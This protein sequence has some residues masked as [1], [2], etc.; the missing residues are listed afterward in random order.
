MNMRNILVSIPFVVMAGLANA[1]EDPVRQCLEVAASNYDENLPLGI[2]GVT[3]EELNV[4]IAIELCREVAESINAD[5][6]YAIQIWYS[7]GRALMKQKNLTESVFFNRKAAISGFPLAQNNLAA[8]IQFGGDGVEAD[9]IEA[10]RLFQMAENGGLAIASYNLGYATER[11]IGTPESLPKAIEYYLRAVEG[12]TSFASQE[13]NRLIKIVYEGD[14]P[15]YAKAATLWR[16]SA[17]AGDSDAQYELAERIRDGRIKASYP[18]E[19]GALLLS[20]F[21]ES[22]FNATLAFSE[23]LMEQPEKLDAMALLA[24]Y[25]AYDLAH[26]ASIDSEY[27]WLLY[28]RNAAL[29]V[30]SVIDTTKAKARDE[31]ELVMFRRDF[32]ANMRAFNVPI[33]CGD[34]TVDFKF[35][36]W[37]W[38]RSYP[39]S[40]EQGEWMTKAR[41]CVF[42]EDV[43]VAFQKIFE[44]A[45][46]K[47]ESFSDLAFA[48]LNAPVPA[49]QA[50]PTPTNVR[51]QA[52]NRIEKF[53][54][55]LA[56]KATGCGFV[57][58]AALDASIGED[59]GA[60]GGAAS[61]V[62]CTALLSEANEFQ[63]DWI[64]L[65]LAG[66]GGAASSGAMTAAGDN[67][68]GEALFSAIVALTAGGLSH[69]KC[70]AS[71]EQQCGRYD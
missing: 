35:Y 26:S 61:S 20:A 43:K 5:S 40:D 57:G 30:L 48:A 52:C 1:A 56:L 11:G 33:N 28:Q 9:P 10:F 64:D 24:A 25:S 16:R 2:D 45:R 18:T 54:A 58:Q 42:P 3:L 66:I 7:Y 69:L 46:S 8:I 15:D 21:S 60:L 19:A 17:T 4:T 13:A 37:D 34:Q 67:R 14:K 29:Q 49:P 38:S 6:E 53:C 22:H 50:Q 62:A 65:G 47:N 23:W 68:I 44:I 39:Q 36:I 31:E 59:T 70:T 71:L 12:G 51:P 41:G 63:L 27:G 32:S 55:E